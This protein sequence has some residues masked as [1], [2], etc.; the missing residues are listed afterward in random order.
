MS[1]EFIKKP[2]SIVPSDFKLNHERDRHAGY[3]NKNDDNSRGQEK[4]EAGDH[5]T[6]LKYMVE[7]AN[8]RLENDTAPFRFGIEQTAGEIIIDIMKV[9]EKGDVI[10]VVKKNITH[11]G[12]LEIAGHI[13]NGEGFLVDLIS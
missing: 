9:D 4:D 13:L 1:D 12:F 6:D 11:E 5:Y 8:D 2:S 7:R 3:E 10:S